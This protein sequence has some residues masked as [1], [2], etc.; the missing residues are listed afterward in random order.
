MRIGPYTI[1]P[2][3]IL[4][5]MAGVTDKPFRVL[6]K[7]LG[8]GLCASEMT[9]SDPRFWNT[10][11]SRHRMDHDGEPAPISVQIAGTVP[12]VMA[13]AAR[14]NVAHG[15]QIIDIN[16]GC[17]AKKVCNA[18][19]GSA[20]MREPALVARICEAVARAVDVPV[21][22]K[23]R[24]G[25]AAGQK[26]AL[27][28]A[29][30]AESAGIAALAMHGRTRD[31]QYTGTAE[32]DTIAEVKAALSIPVVA[33][34]D[35]DSPE[36]AA[37]VLAYTGC[38]AVMVGRAAQ[39]RPWIFR[40]IAH[41]LATGEHLPPPTLDEVR[42]VLLGHLEQLHG[43]YGEVS[44]VRIARKHLGWYAK[45]RPENAAFRAVVNRAET[46][47]AQLALTREYFDALIAG[48]PLAVAA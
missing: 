35:I 48:E 40:E 36:K 38:D 41:Y 23:I 8:A 22:L 43:F 28:I 18:W 10:A 2:H 5:P 44:G 3:V 16:M 17:P 25:W 34:G 32:Y 29:R 6:C 7:R 31:Q 33:N 9:T 21:T 15:A 19:A 20:L 45:D 37:A 39:G 26:N 11:K 4:A 12:E 47:E 46:A 30:I 42:D 1:A 14:Y 24:T 27:E 13:E